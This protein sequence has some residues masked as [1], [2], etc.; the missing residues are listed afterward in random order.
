MDVDAWKERLTSW[1][2]ITEEIIHHHEQQQQQQVQ[3]ATPSVSKYLP[4]FGAYF[5]FSETMKNIKLFVADLSIYTLIL[6]DW[7][8]WQIRFSQLSNMTRSWLLCADVEHLQRAFYRV[9]GPCP[10]HCVITRTN[11]LQHP[12]AN[13][14]FKHS[15]K[16]KKNSRRKHH[17][18][19]HT[20]YIN[21]PSLIFRKLT[22]FPCC[23][24]FS[25]GKKSTKR[26]FASAGTPEAQSSA[27]LNK[28]SSPLPST[29]FSSLRSGGQSF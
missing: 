21:H 7:K 26:S 18:H 24:I 15:N 16:L 1:H 3:T 19:S 27:N 22:H 8:L 5:T 9:S 23:K 12:G 10:V 25:I 2:L 6:A 11:S 28:H 20:A 13:P 4:Y 14:T 17:P 29:S